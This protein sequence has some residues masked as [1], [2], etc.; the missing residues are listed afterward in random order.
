METNVCKGCIYD[1]TDKIV[2]DD[3]TFIEFLDNCCS[4]KRGIVEEHQ[5]MFK[6]LYKAIE[7]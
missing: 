3:K 7:D 1:L 6:D 5:H 2:T 4:C